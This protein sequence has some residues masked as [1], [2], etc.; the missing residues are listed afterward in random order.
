[1]RLDPKYGDPYYGRGMLKLAA[2]DAGVAVSDF[3]KALSLNPLLPL[4]YANRGVALLVQ[5][6]NA[7]AEEDFRRALEYAP[8]L[9]EQIEASVAAMRL[10]KR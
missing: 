10:R 4:A 6:K 2:G 9:R 1:M 7:E 5:G 8:N 3:T